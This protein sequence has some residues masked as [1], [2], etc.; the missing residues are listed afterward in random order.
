MKGWAAFWLLLAVLVVCDTAVVLSGL[1]GVIWQY[2]TPAELE[3]QR[4]RGNLAPA[5]R[6]RAERPLL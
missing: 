4:Q 1:D 3:I 6:P 2:R 5:P